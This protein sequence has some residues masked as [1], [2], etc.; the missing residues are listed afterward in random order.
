MFFN[1][2]HAKIVRMPSVPY[3]SNYCSDFRR[4]CGISMLGVVFISSIFDLLT[5]RFWEEFY[6]L[7]L[8]DCYPKLKFKKKFHL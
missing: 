1:L 5:K 2:L 8:R 7:H 4:K 3:I 6:L